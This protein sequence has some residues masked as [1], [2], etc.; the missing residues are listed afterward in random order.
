MG[1]A[2]VA[3]CG[4]GAAARAHDGT[5]TAAAAAA[6]AVA[7]ARSCS[8]PTTSAPIPAMAPATPHTW[9]DRSRSPAD[10]QTSNVTAATVPAAAKAHHKALMTS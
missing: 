9:L 1:I 4:D 3:A 10:T 6:A 2:D 8:R 7:D 5:G